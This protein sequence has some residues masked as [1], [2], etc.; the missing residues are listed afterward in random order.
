MRSDRGGDG[1][2]SRKSVCRECS[3]RFLVVIEPEERFETLPEFG[4][5]D[6]L[7]DRIRS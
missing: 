7:A 2:V 4:S 3:Q 5:D 1:S 6:F